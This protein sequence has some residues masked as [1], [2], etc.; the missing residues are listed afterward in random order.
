METIRSIVTG[1]PIDWFILGAF[2]ALLTIDSLR[3]GIARTAALSLA[4]PIAWALFSLLASTAFIG[5]LAAS[6]SA[7][8][9]VCLFGVIFVGCFI[10]LRRMGVDFIEA[11]LGQP[12][13]AIAASVSAVT[14]LALFWILSPASDLWTFGPVIQGAFSE[15]Y[16]LFWLVG[17]YGLLV[18]SRG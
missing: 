13:Q 9:A 3:N 12:I 16:R 6:E 15:S 18:F 8:A 10:V 7:I 14:V 2:V 17:A 11:G 1:V 4:A 5:S